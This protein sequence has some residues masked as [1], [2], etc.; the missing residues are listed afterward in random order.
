[1]NGRET[2]NQRADRFPFSFSCST[3]SRPYHL[4]RSPCSTTA[5]NSK[6]GT[7]ISMPPKIRTRKGRAKSAAL[8]TFAI[9]ELFEEIFLRLPQLDLFVLQ[10]TCSAFDTNIENSTVLQAKMYASY[11]PPS[12]FLPPGRPWHEGY[13]HWAA[14]FSHPDRSHLPYYNEIQDLHAHLT[15]LQTTPL[16]VEILLDSQDKTLTMSLSFDHEI[17]SDFPQGN[18]KAA[19]GWKGKS[20]VH[21]SGSWEQIR[22]GMAEAGITKDQHPRRSL[23]AG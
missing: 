11:F 13:S 22:L 7:L 20:I 12:A 4:I 14:I 10:R 2:N 5:F 19:I 15:N 17:V 3:C 18:Y 9:A 8:R 1:M 23:C 16:Y 21:T 6:Q